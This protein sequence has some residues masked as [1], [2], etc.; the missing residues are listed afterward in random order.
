V[1]H[2]IVKPSNRR[3][4]WIIVAAVALIA[5]GVGAFWLGAST[6]HGGFDDDMPMRGMGY[7]LGLRLP[8]VGLLGWLVP[9]VLLGLGIGLL[10]A[11]LRRPDR[12]A[13]PPVSPQAPPPASP[14]APPATPPALAAPSEIN[15]D[16]LR[17]LATMHAEGH[18]TDD[19]F[20]AA[21]RKILGL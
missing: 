4:G 7:G 17:E 21:K 14:P 10:Y 16:A 3:T 11:Y 20:V 12:P 1:E 5:L 18:L 9:A 15:V 8:L 2:P 6:G 19:E 13:P